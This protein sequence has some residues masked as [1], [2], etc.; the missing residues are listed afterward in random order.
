MLTHF[1]SGR[2]PQALEP[3]GEAEPRSGKMLKALNFLYVLHET[4][5]HGPYLEGPGALNIS[6]IPHIERIYFIFDRCYLASYL[7]KALL[8]E[9]VTTP[10]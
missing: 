1:F 4:R 5:G 2:A 7:G 6:E 10:F 9:T 8:C 3:R